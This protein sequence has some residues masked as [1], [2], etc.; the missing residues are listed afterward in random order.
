MCEFDPL[1]ILMKTV[2]A[3]EAKNSFGVLLEDVQKEPVTVSKNGRDVAVMVS[4]KDYQANMSK[5]VNPRVVQFH[6]E[7]VQKFKSS[8]KK[9]AE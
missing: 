3:T 6:E 9:L 5:G 4:A 7:S 8:Y 1:V 2:N